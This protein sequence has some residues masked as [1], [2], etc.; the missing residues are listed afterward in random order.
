M[1]G[2]RPS[3]RLRGPPASDSDRSGR[4]GRQRQRGNRAAISVPRCR[5]ARRRFRRPIRSTRRSLGRLAMPVAAEIGRPVGDRCAP[6]FRGGA[7]LGGDRGRDPCGARCRGSLCALPGL[8]KARTDLAARLADSRN[9]GYGRSSSTDS[10]AL[11]QQA[12]RRNATR[13]H[14]PIDTLT[15]RSCTRRSGHSDRRARATS[16]RA[17]SRPHDPAAS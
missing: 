3:C 9:A 1:D 14:R 16:W 6:R 17:R 8:R 10:R 7:A 2:R 11:G 13:D 5:V 4:A 12:P 15:R